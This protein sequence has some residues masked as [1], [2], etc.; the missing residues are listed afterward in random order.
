MLDFTNENTTLVTVGTEINRIGG[1]VKMVSDSL[2]QIVGK[3]LTAQAQAQQ[4]VEEA[5]AKPGSDTTTPPAAKPGP[6]P[7]VNM[8]ELSKD[9]QDLQQSVSQL[10]G[11]VTAIENELGIAPGTLVAESV[12]AESDVTAQAPAS[13]P[14]T[15][16][17]PHVGSKVPA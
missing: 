3:M 9:V 1:D 7:S 5:K 16:P 8:D 2:N 15:K 10:Q 14:A 13:D 12:K 11:L 17:K 4:K 6:T